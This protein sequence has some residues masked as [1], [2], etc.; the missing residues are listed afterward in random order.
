M[1]K[2]QTVRVGSG[3]EKSPPKPESKAF[4][5]SN[6]SKRKQKHESHNKASLNSASDIRKQ[7]NLMGRR[8][9]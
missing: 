1:S 9:Y 4:R 5:P 7:A 8:V 3:K 6:K 2:L